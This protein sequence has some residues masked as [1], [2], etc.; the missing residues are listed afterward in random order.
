MIKKF[1]NNTEL[2]I[3]IGFILCLFDALFTLSWIAYGIAYEL[4]PIINL[5]II[6]FGIAVAMIIKILFSLIC[7]IIIYKLYKDFYGKKLIHIT[8]N[9]I[10][11]L[12]I[13]INCYHLIF[14]CKFIKLI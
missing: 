3:F 5:F 11:L 6:N 2:I 10:F 1:N 13:L 8:L 4:N 7:F 12:H 9:L 14:F